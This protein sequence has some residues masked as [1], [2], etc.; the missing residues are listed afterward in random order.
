[1]NDRPRLGEARQ[2]LAAHVAA[3]GAEIR[4]KYGPR[5][6]WA[7]LQRMLA[8]RECTRYPC[9]LAFDAEPLLP[10]ELAYPVPLGERPEQGFRLCVHPYFSIDPARVPE[11]ALYQLVLVNYGVF[12]APED[13]ESF[14]AAILGISREEYYRRL[15]AMADE[16]F[17]PE[18]AA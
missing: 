16:I 18:P 11:I 17:L 13:A 7:E 4:E 8:D 6:G 2:S 10:G 12:A 1:M 15:C 14:G 3:R 5:I 9:E